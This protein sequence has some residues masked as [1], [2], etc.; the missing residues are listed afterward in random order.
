VDPRSLLCNVWNALI[1]VLPIAAFFIGL[2]GTYAVVWFNHLL[3]DNLV[4]RA[5]RESLAVELLMNLQLLDAYERDLKALRDEKSQRWPSEA[6]LTNVLDHTGDPLISVVLTDSEKVR[7]TLLRV[8]L[9]TLWGAMV[10]GREDVDRPYPH[11]EFPTPS[12]IAA[13]ADRILSSHALEETGRLVVET[14][15]IVTSKEHFL[16]LSALVDMAQS[17][18]GKRI[19]SAVW[20]TSDFERWP[21]VGG[22]GVAWREDLPGGH[23]DPTTTI[24]WPESLPEFHIVDLEQAGWLTR[25]VPWY[26]RWRSS[27]GTRADTQALARIRAPKR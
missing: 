16:S 22:V 1:G 12:E 15:V 5:T 20:R 13:S 3:R 8:Q 2:A 17:L 11:R 19:D 6:P 21:P 14:L 10:V 7:V 27:R 9:A 26:R 18:E 25:F 4:R 23:P 24:L